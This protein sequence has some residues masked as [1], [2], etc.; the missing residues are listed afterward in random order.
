M[1]KII[2][3]IILLPTYPLIFLAWLLEREEYDE[4]NVWSCGGRAALMMDWRNQ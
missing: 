2:R 3:T 1:K 4:R